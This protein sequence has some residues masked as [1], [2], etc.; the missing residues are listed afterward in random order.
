MDDPN[1]P[2]VPL[3]ARFASD[4]TRLRTGARLTK[5]SLAA[6]MCVHKSLISHVE[7]MRK[8]PSMSFAE[9]ADAA[10]GL[11]SH[12]TQIAIQMANSGSLKWLSKW[13]EE[14][15]TRASVLWTWDPMLVPGL[16][17]TEAY[18]HAVYTTG[19]GPRDGL[20]ERIAARMNRR[21]ILNRSD[22]PKIWMLLDE[23]VLHRP[24]GGVEVLRDQ[25]RS[26][27]EFARHPRV[28]IQ[29]VPTDTGVAAGMI[30]GASTSC[31]L[32]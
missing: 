25:L 18:A 4:L 31:S 20:E 7:G 26:L 16:L 22:P 6:K 14:V 30:S 19:P 1:E 3:Q 12:F 13:V 29:I 24:I 8:R 11:D 21:K 5:V 10:L 23:G 2:W 9:A 15:E 27:A 17:Q 28:S 32:T